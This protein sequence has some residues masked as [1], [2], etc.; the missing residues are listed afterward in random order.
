DNSV[1]NQSALNFDHYF[2][3]NELKSQS[4]EKD[5]VI[6]KLKE[7]IKA[8]SGTKNRDKEK[9]LVIIALKNNLRKLKGK[10]I[11][12]D[13]VTLHTITPEI[14]KVDVE[15]L[16][17]KLLNNRIAHSDYLRHTQEQAAILR[18]VV[19][20]GK[21]QNPLNNYLDHACVKSSISAS[22]LQPLGNTKKDK[23]QQPPSI[24]QKNKH[25]KLNANSKLICVKFNGRLLSNN[26]T[27]FILNDVNARAKSKSV[28]KIKEKSL[29]TN[30][31]R[32]HQYWI[33]LETYWSDLHY[34]RHGL[35]RGLRKLKFKKDH[36]CSACA[37]D[38]SKKKPNKPKSEDT[39]QEKLYLLHTNL[40]GPIRV[41]LRSKDEAPD[42]IIKFLKMIQV[43]LKTPF[44]RIRTDNGTEFVNRTLLEYYEK[45]GISHE[46]SVAHSPQQNGV[47]EGCNRTLVEAACIMLI[48]AK[49][50]LFLWAEAAATACY[51][52]NRSIIH[53]HYEKT[54]YEL[55]HNKPPDLLRVV[56]IPY[57]DEVLMIHG[58]GS[59]GASNS[60]KANVVADALSRNERVKPLRVRALMMTI[61]LNLLSQI[62]NAQ[63]EAIKEENINEENL[64]GMTKRF[65]TR[66]DGTHYIKKQSWVSHSRGLRDLIMNESHKSKY[67]IHPRSDK[68]YHDL[69]KLYWWPNMKAEITT[70]VGDSQLTGSK[71]IHETTEK[72]I[73]IKSQIQAAHDRQKS[74]A[75]VR[76]KPLEF[77]VGDKVMLKV[78]SWKGVIRFSKRGKLNPCYIGPFKILA[79]VGDRL[80]SWESMG[81]EIRLVLVVVLLLDFMVRRN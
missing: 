15:P 70:Y 56:R 78:S 21:S 7:R 30:R 33:H 11:V 74:Y 54:P 59:D 32:V 17:P 64:N 26:H 12:D 1:S 29:E 19:E 60:R 66:S 28:K 81:D 3:L 41:C 5:T 77:Q 69:K 25:F 46:T 75:D 24:T 34:T 42:F 57:R 58:D 2:E 40:C 35:V 50:S 73:Q 4:Q 71:I 9:D 72:I 52:Q 63:V 36:M 65:E 8:L 49:A 45:V 47:V 76:R 18:K 22:G 61:D 38:K 20:Q 39:N 48:C 80:V 67:S 13:V 10:A 51:T 68:M 37:I 27:L 55:L 6:S 23:I 44:Q 14:L 62:L 16:A 79:K 43:R 53:L 31:K